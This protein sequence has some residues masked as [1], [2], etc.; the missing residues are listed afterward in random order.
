MR[1]RIIICL[2]ALLGLAALMPPAPARAQDDL[3][4]ACAQAVGAALSRRG[5][6]YVW[7]AKGPGS[8]DC[9]GLTGWAYAQAGIEIGVGTHDQLLS[10]QPNGC[11]LTQM[12]L[13]T[14]WQPGDLIFLRNGGSQHVS[15]YIGGGAGGR[16]LQQLYGRDRACRSE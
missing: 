7:G 2:A 8:F 11:S 13:N 14:C 16:R 9:S 4:P 5:Y 12:A 15:L 3:S 10:G 6:P 1:L